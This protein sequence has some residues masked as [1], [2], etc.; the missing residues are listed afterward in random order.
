MIPTNFQPAQDVL[1]QVIL[2]GPGE[3]Q[4]LGRERWPAK[5][6]AH[7]EEFASPMEAQ[8]LRCLEG[9][10]PR[11]G[12]GIFVRDYKLVAANAKISLIEAS[13]QPPTKPVSA[14]VGG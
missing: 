5:A 8:F 6:G 13:L 11:K 4:H 1:P 9:E 10:V 2:H 7:P 3:G 14:L 12:V